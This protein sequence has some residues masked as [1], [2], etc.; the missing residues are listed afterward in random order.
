MIKVFEN[1]SKLNVVDDN[2]NFV[3]FDL[4]DDCCAHGGWFV[5]PE[6]CT[7][8]FTEIKGLD[9]TEF[10]DYYFDESFFKEI[11]YGEGGAVAFKLYS[12]NKRD[13]Y[14]HLFNCHNGYYG[15][16]FKSSIGGK[17]GTL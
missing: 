8:D 3:G 9:E 16:G 7:K 1:G 13:V 14:L 6:I 5:H 10:A 17:A 2:N 11:P 15:K 12:Y 4:M